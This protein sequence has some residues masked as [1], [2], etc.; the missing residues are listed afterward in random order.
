MLDC[1]MI[2]LRR[3]TSQFLCPALAVMVGVLPHTLRAQEN[4]SARGWVIAGGLGLGLANV[5]ESRTPVYFD[6]LQQT[7]RVALQRNVGAGM[8]AGVSLTTTVGTEGGD[9]A[10]I[11]PCA[12]RFS[13]RTVSGTL[14]Y[15]RGQR[16]RSWKPM[17]TV[18]AGLAQIPETWASG[19]NA[20]TP[21]KS[22]WQIGAAI[23]FP[24]LVG[25]GTALLLG[26]EGH[27]IP[28][29]PGGGVGV[30]TLVM[31]LRHS[32]FRRVAF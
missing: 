13:H 21:A 4:D 20:R 28:D 3:V 22:T 18:A 12:P 8:S 7:A 17:A 30:N 32:L 31:T 2:N 9:C 5:P 6:A 27:I 11:G 19:L 16:L 23:D 24:V 29:A 1:G 26:W 25:P 10:G 15:V 14:T